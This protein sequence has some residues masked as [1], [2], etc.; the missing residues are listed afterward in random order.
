MTTE[1]G[2]Y[3]FEKPVSTSEPIPLKAGDPRVLI[4]GK[5]VKADFRIISENKYQS[6]IFEPLTISGPLE[7]IENLYLIIM[8]G[9]DA[10]IK[11]DSTKVKESGIRWMD[12]VR[13]A[14]R[15]QE[16]ENKRIVS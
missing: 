2:S 9:I 16:F 8:L 6:L 5:P 10:A 12:T 13:Q 1:S 14:I 11:N 15:D 7:E 4:N 3:T